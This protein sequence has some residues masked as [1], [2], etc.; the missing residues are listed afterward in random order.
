M[1]SKAAQ[2]IQ[3]YRAIIAERL[4]QMRIA[5]RAFVAYMQRPDSDPVYAAIGY[6]PF[7]GWLVPLYLRE[8]SQL[9]QKSGKQGLVL[10]LLGA[11]V[12]LA[13]FGIELFVP[14]SLKPLS[15]SLI[16]LTYI[17]NAGYLTLSVYAMYHA[18]C[19]RIVRIPWVSVQSDEMHL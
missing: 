12:L 15:F 8:K 2:R 18:F 7:V 4:V 11:A 6:L 3:R 5:V 9:C 10:S 17:F 14:R 16:L 19:G 1:S 13:L